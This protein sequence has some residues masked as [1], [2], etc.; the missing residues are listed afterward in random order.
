MA[1]TTL[2][3]S[4]ANATI[5]V[6]APRRP[7]RRRRRG[8]LWVHFSLVLAAI[9][10]MIPFLWF[11]TV[12]LRPNEQLYQF[13]PSSLTLSNFV[14]MAN[15]VPEMA[16]YYGDS[17]IITGV[18]V[19]ITAV[20][21]AMAGYAFERLTFPGRN[22]IFWIVVFTTF[23]PPETAVA[24]LYVE[25]FNLGLLDTRTGLILVYAAWHLGLGTF[26]MRSVFRAIPRELEEAARIDGAST[27][28]ILWRIMVPLAAGGMVVV[29]L[30]TFVYV[31]GEYL[32]AYTFAGDRVRPMSVG[33]KLFQPYAA[34]PTYTFTIAA[35]ASLVMFV[36]AILIY[37]AFQRWFTK[38]L[39][40]GALK[41]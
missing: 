25:L 41:G 33:I 24:S 23:I 9:V 4:G 38:G 8:Q 10:L 31:W 14:D 20:V 28:T 1:Q 5:A 17:A 26:I 35:A 34:D 27:W 32:F 19:A 30:L 12:A 7:S 15:R 13:L 40:M 29:A 3:R 18:A 39:L 36:P 6:G 22:A 16:S 21:S 11:V 37:I 2:E